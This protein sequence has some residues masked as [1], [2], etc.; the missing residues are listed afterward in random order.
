M[1]LS[2]QPYLPLYINDWLS[3]SKLKSCSASAHGLMINIM[4]LMHKEED[5]GIILLKQKFKQTDKQINNFA[6]QLVKLLPFD[7]V[8]IEQG[9]IELI[10]EKCLFITDDILKCNRMIKDAD[11]SLKRSL[12][13]SKGGKETMKKPII[14]NDFASKFAQAKIKAKPE[15]EYIIDTVIEYLNIKVASDF[16]SKTKETINLISAR[17]KE[18]YK[19]EDFKKVIDIKSD[20]WLN[21]LAMKD[22]LRPATLFGTKFE[23]YLNEVPKINPKSKLVR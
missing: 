5:Y 8:E 13:G 3:N 20:K 17:I 9:L 11:I 2:N 18:G 21:D 23:S 7:A 16:K 6:L 4:A 14:L 12:S 15:Y 10:E 19:I 22:Y 1:A